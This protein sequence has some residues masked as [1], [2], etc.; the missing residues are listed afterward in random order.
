MSAQSS[1]VMRARVIGTLTPVLA[2]ANAN[3]FQQQAYSV[4]NVFTRDFTRLSPLKA[5]TQFGRHIIF[6]RDKDHDYFDIDQ[7]EIITNPATG[8]AAPQVEQYVDGAGYLLVNKP[9]YRF[10]N[11][12]LNSVQVPWEWH[13]LKDILGIHIT[14][15]QYAARIRE[16]YLVDKNVA[17]LQ[18]KLLRGH[19]F[20][21]DFDMGLDYD[22]KE[23][24]QFIVGFNT[25]PR[26]EFDLGN[27]ADLINISTG[28][29]PTNLSTIINSITMIQNN[30]HIL[31]A[32]RKFEL[33]RQDRANGVFVKIHR[34]EIQTN[35][36]AAGQTKARIEL[37][38]TGTHE[39]AF[40]IFT[41]SSTSFAYGNNF[42]KD[43]AFW[44]WGVPDLTVVPPTYTLTTATGTLRRPERFHI[45]SASSNIIF[46]EQYVSYN[47]EVYLQRF[48]PFSFGPGSV[49]LALFTEDPLALNAVMGSYDFN[50]QG[51]RILVIDWPSGTTSSTTDTWSVTT[52]LMG[53][54]W[55]QN[56]MGGAVQILP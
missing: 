31:P 7:L 35:T 30:V 1:L 27:A 20:V 56:V 55:I 38:S 41:P 53:P 10:T 13:R 4:I 52:I 6:E 16:N 29:Q 9:V 39:A 49:L 50:V 23:C 46:P 18:L 32:T 51:S 11:Q 42:A 47:N 24:M 17:Y 36:I 19:Q 3:F 33:S 5:E 54:N 43:P 8:L 26:F 28:N 40:F 12:Q 14:E 44:S 37:L 15:E 34:F 48:F 45:E 22:S 21:V 2:S 25:R